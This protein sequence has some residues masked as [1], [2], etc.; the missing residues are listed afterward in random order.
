MPTEY[1]H[2]GILHLR[3]GISSVTDEDI[4]GFSDIKD[5][6]KIKGVLQ[7]LKKEGYL[8]STSWDHEKGATRVNYST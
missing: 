6:L 7:N 1:R 5:L 2:Q 3:E 4:R 8:L